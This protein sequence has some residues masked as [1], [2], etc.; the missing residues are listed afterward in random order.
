MDSFS[1]YIYTV[2]VKGLASHVDK[3]ADLLTPSKNHLFESI[4]IFRFIAFAL[5]CRTGKC[6]NNQAIPPPNRARFIIFT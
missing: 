1:V 2:T 4:V 3:R 5:H 6:Y